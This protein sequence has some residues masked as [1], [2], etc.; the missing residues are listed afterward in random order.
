M[1]SRTT[2]SISKM[3]YATIHIRS[4]GGRPGNLLAALTQIRARGVEVITEEAMIIEA[5]LAHGLVAGEDARAGF[6]VFR[7]FEQDAKDFA[8]FA[9]KQLVL[10]PVFPS[11]CLRK[12]RVRNLSI[13]QRLKVG[14][15]GG[16]DGMT[17]MLRARR[18]GTRAPH[19]RMRTSPFSH[20]ATC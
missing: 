13:K 18:A 8:G 3:C 11:L 1:P 17:K 10:T 7:N 4:G 12:P 19:R 5:E 16:S 2:F 9:K 14:A 6:E 15:P 20:G